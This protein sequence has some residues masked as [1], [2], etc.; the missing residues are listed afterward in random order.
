VEFG[1][2]PGVANGNSVSGS[3]TGNFFDD[4]GGEYWCADTQGDGDCEKGSEMLVV[5][6]YTLAWE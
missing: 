1:G 6:E 4:N 2:N 5:V 3:F